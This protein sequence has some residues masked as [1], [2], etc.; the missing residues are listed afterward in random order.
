VLLVASCVAAVTVALS[1]AATPVRGIEFS[2]AGHWIANP[3]LGLLFHI[4]GASKDVDV[5]ATVPGL[6]PGSQVVQGDTNG[7]VVG[8]A[9]VLEFGK[10]SLAVEKSTELPTGELPVSGVPSGWPGRP[11]R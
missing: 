8:G 9:K 1:G 2:Q 11:P 6:E 10:S 4:N 7:Y 5:Q 3:A